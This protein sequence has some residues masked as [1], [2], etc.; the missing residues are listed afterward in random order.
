[1]K[2]IRRLFPATLIILTFGMSVAWFAFSKETSKIESPVDAAA[3]QELMSNEIMDFIDLKDLIREERSLFEIITPPVEGYVLQQPIYPVIPFSWKSFPKDLSVLLGDRYVYEY[4]VP[5]YKLRAVE[6]RNTRQLHFY[7]NDKELIFSIDPAIDYDPFSWL[8]ARYPGLYS[9]WY[10]SSEIGEFEAAYDPARVELIVTLIPIE[11]VEQYLYAKDRVLDYQLSLIEEGGGEYM[12]MSMDPSSNIVITAVTWTTNGAHLEV[13]YPENFEDQLE[14]Y[15]ATD[16]IERDWELVSGPLNTTGSTSVVWMDTQFGNQKI[17]YYAVGNHDLDSDSDQFNDAFEVFVLGTDA[18]D[19]DSHGVYFTGE[20]IYNGPETGLIHI[21]AVPDMGSWAKTWQTVI[22]G[23]GN[24]TNLAANQQEYWFKAFMDVNWNNQEDGWEPWGINNTNSLYATTDVSSLDITLED[25]PSIWG[26]IDYSGGATGDI[27]VL[28]TTQPGWDTTNSTVISWLQ[29]EASLTGGPVYVSFPVDYSITDLTAGSYIVRAFIDENSDGE[30]TPLEPG[31][32]Y[33][34]TIA[35]S[36][37]VTDIDFTIDLDSDEDELPDWWEIQYFTNLLQNAGGDNDGDSLNNSNEYLYGTNPTNSDTDSDSMDDGWEVSYGFDPLD[38]IDALQ[39]ADTNGWTNLEENE[40]QSDPLDPDSAPFDTIYVDDVDGSDTNSGSFSNPFKT[41]QAGIDEAI[42]DNWV[43]I[44][45][46]TYTGT[47][48]RNLHYNGKSIKLRSMMNDA[49]SVVIDAESLGRVFEFSAGETTNALVSSVT[50]TGGSA[51]YGAG[52]YCYTSNPTFHGLRVIENKASD[53]GGGLFAA[54][55]Q[56]TVSNCYFSRNSALACGGGAWFEHWYMSWGSRGSH[57]TIIDTSFSRNRAKTGAAIGF[58]DCNPSAAINGYYPG[59]SVVARCRITQNQAT[60]K[61]NL[62]IGIAKTVFVNDSYIAN[63]TGPGV[64]NEYGNLFFKQS[65]VIR[66]RSSGSSGS[67]ITSWHIPSLD[68]QT[69]IRNSIVRGNYPEEDQIY[70]CYYPYSPPSPCTV[71]YAA[72]NPKGSFPSSPFFTNR[73]AYGTGCIT[74]DPLVAPSG[75]ILAGSPVVDA[76]NSSWA[77]AKDI[78]AEARPQGTAPDMGAD[79][80]IDSNGDG[81]ADWW[82]VMAGFGV[83]DYIDPDGN[84]NTNELTNEQEY[85]AGTDPYAPLVDA[86][87]DGLSD[88]AEIYYGSDPSDWDSDNDYLSDGFERQYTNL[89]DLLQVDIATNDYDNDGLADWL[90]SVYQTLPDDPDSDGDGVLDG[91]ELQN[92]T[93]PNDPTDADETEPEVFEIEIGC[94]EMGH[95]S[96]QP[97]SVRVGPYQ[98]IQAIGAGVTESFLVF[99]PG[100]MTA[101]IRNQNGM[102]SVHAGCDGGVR[103]IKNSVKSSGWGAFAVVQHFPSLEANSYFGQYMF[104]NYASWYSGWTQWANWNDYKSFGWVNGCSLYET[105]RALKIDKPLVYITQ[106]NMTADLNDDGNLNEADDKLE[107]NTYLHLDAT[108]SVKAIEINVTPEP[109]A[110]FLLGIGSI[111]GDVEFWMDE[112][113]TEP[114]PDYFT[115]GGSE[116]TPSTLYISAATG[117]V[118]DV[119]ELALYPDTDD[120]IVPISGIMS[121]VTSEYCIAVDKFKASILSVDLTAHRPYT[122]G[123]DYGNPFPKTAVPD[124]KEESPGAGIR[125][126]GDGNEGANENDLIEVQIDV[127][128]F[129]VPSGLTYVLKRSS[130]SI[131][132]WDSKDMSGSCLLD[133]AEEEIAISS[134]PMSVW[135]ENPGGGDADLELLAMSGSTDVCSDKVHFYQ[136]TSVL[137]GISGE[138]WWFMSG[139]YLDHGSYDMATNLYVDG[140]DVHYFDEDDVDDNGEDAYAEVVNAIQDRNVSKV[141]IYG[142]SHGGGCTFILS[143]RLDD[144]RASNGT[145]SIDATAYIDAIEDDSWM[146]SETLTNLPPAAAYHA[147]Y[148]QT[149][150][151]A[152]ALGLHG[153]NI[154]GASFNLN[155]NTTAWGGGLHHGTIDDARQVINGV[156]EKIRANIDR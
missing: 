102:S 71:E 104:R 148:Y 1:M 122:E 81:F 127:A 28:A 116:P 97:W 11:Y 66:N 88:S 80:Y 49:E 154:F 138:D 119:V 128:P 93:N 112:A 101:E 2:T 95:D 126:N 111:D 40:G 110:G 118:S 83:N 107:E 136:F 7:G 58:I 68:G 62:Y 140:Y 37:R 31:G 43:F 13:G 8:K 34:L 124:D 90:E 156:V 139:S 25:Q 55:S 39:D 42:S 84:L 79:E 72:F 20:I 61:G 30:F 4:S 142:Y 69:S 64:Y 70:T 12:M 52:I 85:Y 109:P 76:A 87:S 114:A 96:S 35:L 150:V 98:I 108:G 153:T 82:K 149:N 135:V 133:A 21:V 59:T 147:N 132:V 47:N 24:Y 41:I 89:Y 75:H 50:I 63:N 33:N 99:E 45:P 60:G 10:S 46:G 92:E 32:Q 134:S 65:S 113:K 22:P 94:W 6:D 14:I 53:S 145:F 115:Y 56:I 152:S 91:T 155:V 78:D 44:K 9:G 103:I 36:N 137:V 74:N 141:G 130:S 125:V 123:P 73:T 18:Q 57:A 48:N 106:I 129:P 26:T 27:Y 151:A 146:D 51:E 105:N 121:D 117:M 86:D 54:G 15:R 143:Q 19:A 38:A 29:G 16:L 77:T 3:Y 5:V 100:V 131:K 67:G 120:T 144:N 23:A 17:R